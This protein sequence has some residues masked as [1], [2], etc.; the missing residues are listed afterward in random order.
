MGSATAVIPG[1]GLTKVTLN[2]TLMQEKSQVIRSVYEHAVALGAGFGP[3]CAK[4]YDVFIPL[5]HFQFSADI[6]GTAAQTMGAVLESSC[7]YMEMGGDVA[8]PKKFLPV[9][10]QAISGQLEQEEIWDIE[11][12]H[13]LADAL[14]ETA[15]AMYSYAPSSS[16]LIGSVT[17]TAVSKVV[18]ICMKLLVSCLERRAKIAKSV[19]EA[20]SEDERFGLSSKLAQEENLLVPL[21]DTVGYTLKTYRES[22]VPIF[23][24][25]VVP[26]LSPFLSTGDDIRA[27]LS[28]VCLFDDCV[29]F[30]GS[31]AAETF[32]PMLLQGIQNGLDDSKNGADD[33]LKRAAI[34]GVAQI[35]RYAPRA[36][37]LPVAQGLI[38]LLASIA[39]SPLD[40]EAPVYENS[41]SALASLVLFEN[42]PFVGSGFVKREL[43]MGAFLESL[44]L[45]EDPDEAK[46]CHSGFCDLLECGLISVDCRMEEIVCGIL[47]LVEDGEDVANQD[48]CTR[49]LEIR[50][51]LQRGGL[52]G[53]R[54]CTSNV[55][56]P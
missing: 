13:A 5:I 33:E 10:L 9:L 45:S 38:Q 12:V 30:C 15:C 18:E 4:C 14:S 54:F 39:T 25:F 1:K 43:V 19:K 49:L 41:I 42:A 46:I 31:A 23:K 37:L 51:Q 53:D 26:T 7:K 32:S 11:N 2:T 34:Y 50:S 29:E 24:T 3:Y 48:T 40:H 56:S 35:A 16:E 44:P 52:A 47:S 28:A 36:V 21:V 22:F 6:R 55:V 20:L 27:R 17:Q 8:T